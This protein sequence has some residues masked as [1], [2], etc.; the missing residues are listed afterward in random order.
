MIYVAIALVLLCLVAVPWYVRHRFPDDVPVMQGL[1][2]G[3]AL[4]TASALLTALA[5][6][7]GKIAAALF[8]LL[9]CTGFSVISV[10]AYRYYRAARHREHDGA[11]KA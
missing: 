2:N 8:G 4:T 11:G 10:R 7:T 9:A 1:I 6:T 3:I 5:I